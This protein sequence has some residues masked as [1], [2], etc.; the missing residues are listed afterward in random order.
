MAAGERYQY[1]N[2][3]Q[4]VTPDLKREIIEFWKRCN[5]LPPAEDPEERADQVVFIVRSESGEIAGLNTAVK[6]FAKRFNNSFYFYR[7]MTAPGF[8]V[9]GIADE[10]VVRTRDFL[11]DLFKRE[12]E[13][14]CIGILMTLES[15]ILNTRFNEAIRP[16]KFIFMGYNERGHQ[17]RVYYFEG[18]E[19]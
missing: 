14:T 8:R 12:T 5:A 1:E 7:T 11:E 15:E 6:V 13:K 16:N 19:I 2:V 4:K 18:A 10:L 17:I 3:W 9:A